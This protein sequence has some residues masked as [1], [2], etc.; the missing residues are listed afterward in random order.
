MISFT[1]KIASVLLLASLSASVLAAESNTK[2]LLYISP[3]DYNY[4]VHLLAPYYEYWFEQGPLVEPIALKALQE[5]HGEMA[6]AYCLDYIER[7]KHSHLTN[8]AEFTA[9]FPA[10]YEAQIH[11]SSSWSC[12]H[13]V[14]RWC[15]DCGCNSGG[16]PTWNQ[17]WRKP[18]REALDWL[19]DELIIIY[20]R[21]AS[22]QY[23][24]NLFYIRQCISQRF[25]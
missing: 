8:Y 5:K 6:L 4:S 19:R 3:N 15:N 1:K 16:N 13:G 14:E 9:K 21:E 12:V 2:A 18:L 22:N 11:E 10:T 23:W 24:R 17:K 7:H 20:D 25:L